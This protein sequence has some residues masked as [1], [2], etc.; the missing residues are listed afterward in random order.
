MRWH[1][2]VERRICYSNVNS[3]RRNTEL[4]TVTFFPHRAGEYY[5]A[6]WTSRETLHKSTNTKENIVIVKDEMIGSALA[7]RSILGIIIG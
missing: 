5:V 3:A 1:H 6:R 7:R 2:E 4:I